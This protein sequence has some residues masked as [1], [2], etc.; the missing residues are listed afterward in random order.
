MLGP[1]DVSE[2]KRELNP[3]IAAI[4]LAMLVLAAVYFRVTPQQRKEAAHDDMLARGTV[5]GAE[6]R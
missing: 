6:S 5:T 2:V 4:F 1:V 3:G